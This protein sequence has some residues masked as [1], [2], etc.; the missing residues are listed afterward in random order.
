MPEKRYDRVRLPP[1]AEPVRRSRDRVRESAR[2]DT[3]SPGNGGLRALLL[4]LERGVVHRAGRGDAFAAAPEVEQ[5]LERRRGSGQPLPGRAREQMESAFGAS[6]DDVTIH[7]GGE[8]DD[9]SRKVD[10][11]AFT[12]GSDIY[13]S[14][15]AYAPETSHGQRLLAHELTHVVQQHSARK[16]TVGAA[17]DPAESEADAVADAV[18]QRLQAA[19]PATPVAPATV[20]RQAQP[21][22]DEEKAQR[23]QR[24]PE[25]EEDEAQRLQ[26]RPEDDEDERVQRLRR[27]EEEVRLVQPPGARRL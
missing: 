22:E 11:V 7:T 21:E 16:V 14:D 10:A 1:R 20:A 2:A 12:H 3:R 17:Y 19:E 13:F 9:L 5:A 27:Q 25:D 23:L 26:R 18:V 6:F 4:R 15:G 8:A 24:Q